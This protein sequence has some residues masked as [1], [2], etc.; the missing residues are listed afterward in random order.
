MNEALDQNPPSIK[1]NL[2]G[3]R[4]LK[5]N[6]VR[7]QAL[8][9]LDAVLHD[10]RYDGSDLI[11]DFLASR[12]D[13]V[14]SDLEKPMNKNDRVKI[15]KIYNDG[16]V[17]RSREVTI[18]VDLCGKSGTL[19]ADEQMRRLVAYCEALFITH[20]H[21]DHCDDNVVSMF[22]VDRSLFMPLP[23][24]SRLTRGQSYPLGQAEG[25]EG[26]IY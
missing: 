12:V 9:M 2:S 3:K 22:T 1:P 16:F 13:R 10:T 6:L 23:T 17:I 7:K 8:Y 18:A 24:M 11:K 26:T 15:Y 14:L 21:S 5:P 25:N 19:I 4:A 20:N